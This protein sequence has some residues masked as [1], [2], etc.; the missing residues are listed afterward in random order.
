M[1]VKTKGASPFC[2]QKGGEGEKEKKKRKKKGGGGPSFVLSRKAILKA[3]GAEKKKLLRSIR[4][5]VGGGK[6]GME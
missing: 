6:E 1:G 5:Q 4:L 2:D 3:L